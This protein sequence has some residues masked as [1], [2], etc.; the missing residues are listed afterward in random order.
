MAQKSPP[1]VD[2]PPSPVEPYPSTYT[3]VVETPVTPILEIPLVSRNTKLCYHQNLPFLRKNDPY[4]Y[5]PSHGSGFRLFVFG[6]ILFLI[7]LNLQ[8]YIESLHPFFLIMLAI[9]ALISIFFWRF[10]Y[11]S[12]LV[13]QRPNPITDRI[14]IGRIIRIAKAG[15]PQ[16]LLLAFLFPER[17]TWVYQFITPEQR[18]ITGTLTRHLFSRDQQITPE[19]GDRAYIYYRNDNQY[20]LL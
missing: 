15:E 8:L 1:N 13:L 2:S 16:N 9:V 4:F 5:R 19:G 12:P 11:T 14:L 18:T 7:W 20:S 17:V 6:A 10:R 3:P